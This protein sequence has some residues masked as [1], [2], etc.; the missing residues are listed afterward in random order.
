MAETELPNPRE[1]EEIKERKFHSKIALITAVYAVILA[2]SSL[3]G[4][5][6]MKEM[7]LAQQQAS[8]QWAY[9][10]AKSIREHLYKSQKMMLEN[11]LSLL[12]G[13]GGAVQTGKVDATIKKLG[14]ESAR[15]SVEKKK[16][17]EKALKLEKERDKNLAK[18]PYFEYA[19]VLLQIAII[20]AS[21]S[22]IADSPMVFCL[23]IA[24]ALA[25]SFMCANG[26]LQFV[27]MGFIH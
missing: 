6:A 5:H 22:I 19:E 16:I 25:G 8:D 11:E 14:E 26:Y 3:G 4:N 15:F 2:F 20:M 18:D 1:L 12:A 10:Q 21:V 23:S 9:Y 13:P 24:F 7:L 27:S 17:M